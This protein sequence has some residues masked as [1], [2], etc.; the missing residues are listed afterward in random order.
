MDATLLKDIGI[1]L[2]LSIIVL[3]ICYRFRIPE[4]I[5]FLVT[6]V[7]AG[8][9]VMG[10]FSNTTEIEY[11]ADI[12]IVLLLF[13]IGIEFSLKR[14]KE[15]KKQ[16]LV[17]GT[18]QVILTFLV[19][20]VISAAIGMPYKTAI[21]IGFAISLSST[22]IVLRVLQERDEIDS[23]HGRIIIGILIF[24]DIA[25]VAMMLAIQFMTGDAVSMITSVP[26]MIVEAIFVIILTIVGTVWIVPR[27]LQRVARTR[28]QELFMLSI[29][30]LCLAMAW[31]TSSIGLSLAL[32]A[33]LAGLIVSESQYSQQALGNILPFRYV[34]TSF[35]F[36][37]I[38]MLLDI[39]FVL[40]N[41]PIIL[42]AVVSIL[43]L[44]TVLACSTTLLMKYP[45][46][47]AVLSG[48]ALSQ[49]GEFSFILLKLGADNGMLSGSLYQFMLAASIL[50]MAISPFMIGLSP[51][52]SDLICGLPMFRMASGAN[53]ASSKAGDTLKDHLV[54][55][56]YGLNGRNLSEAARS[57]DIPYVIIE[58]NPDTVTME[59]AKGKPIIYG[60]ATNEKVL[61]HAGIASARVVVV[62]IS[63]AAATRRITAIVRDLNPKIHVIVRTRYLNEMGPLYDA[64]ASEVIPEEFETSVEI[65]SRV[66]KKYLVPR[67]R[68]DALTAELR[69]ESYE[70]LRKRPSGYRLADVSSPAF[71]ME[72]STVQ[73]KEGSALANKTIEES[74]LRKKY[75]VTI[76]LVKR[77]E[78]TI[79]NPGAETLL[80]PDDT[81]FMF[82]EPKKLLLVSRLCKDIGVQ[83]Q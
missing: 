2:A 83:E 10:V 36:I 42:L 9:Y 47:T 26:L 68:I 58:M 22:A 21:L 17:G 60:D 19:A 18:L 43:A 73:V 69:A 63:D 61:E 55:I 1:V 11:L 25:S 35:F 8:P 20:S 4:I 75:S 38:G 70:M 50:T 79:H 82:G 29:V 64:G 14:L 45:M 80:Q 23:P 77:G 59:K 32:G 57:T 31:L 3:L 37:S 56:G 62:A 66:M 46:R 27:V 52:A 24:Q 53:E 71:D 7:L 33:F 34:F 48:L 28:S 81:I 49:V 41:M 39:R 74:D 15:L 44:K 6:G 40:A 51:R 67:D 12:G 76:L 72:I 30:V 16:F 65:F 78:E 13:T 5:G 54:I